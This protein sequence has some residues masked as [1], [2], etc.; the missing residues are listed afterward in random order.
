KDEFL[1]ILGHELRTPLAA[2]HNALHVL[3]A[4][5]A[6][7]AAAARAEEVADRQIVQLTRLVDDLLDVSRVG[8]DK[9][10]PQYQRLDLGAL[11]GT[12]TEDH[13]RG[14]DAAGMSLTVE[15]HDAP[16]WVRA[17]PDR[18]AQ[19]VSNLL[20]NAAKFTDAGGHVVVRVAPSA[21]GR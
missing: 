18:M 6:D 12:L 5:G 9:I 1:A 14:L 16:L 21:D 20:N 3:R 2:L 19:V 15:R 4:R 8:R 17:D 10:V 7:P 13:R 11:V